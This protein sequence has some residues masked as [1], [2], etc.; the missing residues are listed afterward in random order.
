MRLCF[1]I[2]LNRYLLCSMLLGCTALAEPASPIHVSVF[3]IATN[4]FDER[5]V[6]SLLHGLKA[7]LKT[8]TRLSVID[9]DS[10]LADFA[11]EIPQTQLDDARRKAHDGDKALE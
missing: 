1:S 4:D 9:L 2:G 11:Q 3:P 8:H 5:S 7:G 6:S 10:R